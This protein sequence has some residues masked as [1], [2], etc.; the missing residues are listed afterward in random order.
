MFEALLYS[1]LSVVS[2][3]LGESEQIVKANA[4]RASNNNITHIEFYEIKDGKRIYAG[5]STREC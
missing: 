2:K 4:R 5:A 1:K 3:V